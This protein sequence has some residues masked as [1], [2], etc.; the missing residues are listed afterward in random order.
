M[1]SVIPFAAAISLAG[2]A[3]AQEHVALAVIGW[4]PLAQDDGVTAY[5]CASSI[6]ARDSE[7][8]YKQQPHR[9][10]LTLAEFERHHR[11]IA[12]QHRGRG[13]LRDLRIDAL[14]TE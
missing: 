6:C 9:P 10:A 4:E 14:T 13:S 1:R 8:S 7:V 11:Q 2:A 5:R 12:E 3:M